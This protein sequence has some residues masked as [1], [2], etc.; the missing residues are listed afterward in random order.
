MQMQMFASAGGLFGLQSLGGDT[1]LQN[2]VWYHLAYIWNQGTLR[3]YLN[4][5]LEAQS[6]SNYSSGKKLQ[7]AGDLTTSNL[8]WVIGSRCNCYLDEFRMWNRELTAVEISQNMLAPISATSANLYRYFKFDT[9][10][11]GGNMIII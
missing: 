7:Y 6:T 9:Q 4:G 8:K 2:D 10:I 5:K 1:I 11:N 3:M